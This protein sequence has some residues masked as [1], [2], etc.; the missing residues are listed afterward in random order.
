MPE[1]WSNPAWIKRRR[2][3]GFGE[4]EGSEYKPWITVRDFGSE[5]L[6]HRIYGHKT[7]RTHHL[8]SNPELGCFLLLEWS[9]A[10][11]DIREQFPLHPLEETQE[12]AT[13][14]G[15]RHPTGTRKEKGTT[16]REEMTMTTDF[17]VTL[18]DGYGAPEMMVTVKPYEKLKKRRNLQKLEIER[19]FAA[20]RGIPWVIVTERQMPTTLVD[21]LKLLHDYFSLDGFAV[22]QED[23]PALLDK[24]CGMLL[25]APAQPLSELCA[26][27]DTKLSLQ[28]GSSLALTWHAIG[29]KTW[30]VDLATPLNP[31]FPLRGLSNRAPL[32]VARGSDE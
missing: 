19:R 29:T 17:R 16:V 31:D 21:N 32:R 28:P 22:P 24:L 12:I 2:D 4:G 26:A 18:A 7:R 30:R 20:R 5:G 27:A 11:T 25:S 6:A 8:M 14:L 9:D 1:R 15:Y 13:E 10:T 23:K 3:Q